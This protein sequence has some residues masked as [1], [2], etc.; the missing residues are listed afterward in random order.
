LRP[1]CKPCQ[2]EYE[3]TWNSRN[4]DVRRA[5]RHKRA[6]AEK[7]YR[8]T[9]DAENRG[10]LLVME[11]KRRSTRKNHPFDL[12]Q[13]ITELEERIKEGCEMTGVA[14]NLHS[15]G[16]TWNSPSLDRIDPQKGYVLSNIRVIC[17]AMNAA[18]GNWG[19]ES[20]R[21]LMKKWLER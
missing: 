21:S 7:A 20:L 1:I 8:Q 14:F 10:R 11:S 16:A 13:H 4:K 19:E 5:Y 2:R 12:D 18:L 3:K 15:R 17:F 9:Y 6:E